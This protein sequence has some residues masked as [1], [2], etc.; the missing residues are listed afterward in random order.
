MNRLGAAILLAL[1]LGLAAILLVN[2][3]SD[4]TKVLGPDG[5]IGAGLDTPSGRAMTVAVIG[6]DRN[7]RTNAALSLVDQLRTDPMVSRVNDPI[8]TNALMDWVWENRLTLA[9]PPAEAVT[10]DAMAETLRR[11]AD[12]FDNFAE[13]PLAP[14]YLLDPTGS[15][16]RIIKNLSHGAP[17]L[18]L[19]N[20]ILQSRDDSASLIFITLAAEPFEV[21]RQSTLNADIQAAVAATGHIALIVGPRPTSAQ[22]STRISH[23][24]TISA[25]VATILLLGWLIW[26][27]RS[28]SGL[29]RVL[30]PIAIGVGAAALMV[31]A[32]FGAVHVLALGF[33][34]A[35]MGLAID[36]PIHLISHST[37]PQIRKARRWILLG[38]IT[39]AIAFLAITVAGIEAL[40][41]IGVFVATGLVGAAATC[42]WLGSGFAAGRL[43]PAG[44]H[45]SSILMPHP[46]ST[47]AGVALIAGVALWLSPSG[48]PSSMVKIPGSVKADIT[49]MGQLQDLPS[50]RLRIEVT[51]KNLTELLRAQKQ[52]QPVLDAAQVDQVLGRW[53]MLVDLIPFSDVAPPTPN[54]VTKN[55]PDALAQAGLATTF[56]AEVSEAYTAAYTT[57]A[58][59]KPIP[60]DL[61]EGSGLGTLIWRENDVLTGTVH[62]WNVQD[63]GTLAQAVIGMNNPNIRF[64]NQQIRI[65][66]QLRKLT[67]TV[68]QSLGIGAVLALIF[69]A[70][71]RRDALQ[72]AIA[73]AAATA[74][75]ALIISLV[76]GTLGIFQIVALVLVTGIGID[77]GLFLRNDDDEQ[78][79]QVAASSVTRCAVTT[80]IAFVTMAFS[81][82][83]VLQNIGMTVSVG[84]LAML[85]AHLLRM[86]R[87]GRG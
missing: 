14:R 83:T 67:T 72:I 25:G 50:G 74:L 81:G 58:A 7:A 45:P 52:L 57:A 4:A 68:L 47:L 79:F 85:V 82:V 40:T 3:D 84:V 56:A 22:I 54:N 44:W 15:F 66:E 19:H 2:L 49:R 32:L 71:F 62:L 36:Y 26:L 65:F 17:D 86:P 12:S 51:G 1:L 20:G 63:P 69:L 6:P 80:L 11:A 53:Q 64:V 30:L 78:A 73:T 13:A 77:Y 35:L 27:T 5:Q 76:T 34:G 59:P 70:L 38:A 61:L 43:R 31:Q 60:I 46:V 16:R 48:K 87:R 39:T 37:E 21:A 42:L 33:G 75:T 41:Q 28:A 24:A 10:S 9:P 18:T 55:L 8:Y 29:L 23:R